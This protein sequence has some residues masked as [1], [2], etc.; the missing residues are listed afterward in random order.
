MRF[1]S[2]PSTPEAVMTGD[3]NIT[4]PMFTLKSIKSTASKFAPEALRLCGD[5]VKIKKTQ[6]PYSFLRIKP[7]NQ[8]KSFRLFYPSSIKLT[9]EQRLCV[10]SMN[11]YVYQ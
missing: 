11:V 4:P 9:T 5:I 3:F 7:K 10:F 6:S 1:P 2:I 8:K